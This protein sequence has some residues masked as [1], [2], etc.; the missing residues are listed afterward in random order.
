L[1]FNYFLDIFKIVEGVRT[2]RLTNKKEVSRMKILVVGGGGREHALVWKISQSPIVSKIYCALGNAGISQQAEYVGIKAN[3]INALVE[4]AEKNGIALTVV[5]PEAPLIAGIVDEFEEKELKIVGPTKA[6]AQ[7]EGSKVFAKKFMQ[8]YGIPTADFETFSNPGEAREYVKNNLPCV[9]KAD[10]LAAGKGAIP[11]FSSEEAEKAIEGIMV[12]KEFGEAGNQVV[13]EEFLE[14]EEATFKVFTDGYRAIPMP[15]TQD[16][17]PV[18]DG[19]KG[20]NTGGMGAYAPAPV[21]TENLQKKIMERII[22]PT[23]NGMRAEGRLY[24]G[25]LYAGLM[26]T[27][28]GY[29]KVLEFNCRF[30]DPEF[31]PIVPLMESDIVPILEGVADGKLPEEKIE[32]SEGAAVCVVMTSAGYP[33]KYETGK[34]IKGLGDAAKM[35]NV[36]VFHAGT[37]ME[38][39]KILTA[40][41]R[42]LGVTAKAAGIPEAINLAY[43]AVSKISWDGEHHRTDIG[44]KALRHL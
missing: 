13:V 27:L 21:I 38:N 28:D 26:I 5:G 10:G 32:W 14:G 31:Q 41:G 24:K 33:G 16:H 39:D 19:D 22:I 7:I 29:P 40:G 37:K 1:T 35:E 20:P 2:L 4:F 8:K 44:Q 6:A 25:T 23:I 12:K 18:F 17:K 11:C 3:D 43:Q 30:G 36:V 34:E 9:V 42:V 15:A